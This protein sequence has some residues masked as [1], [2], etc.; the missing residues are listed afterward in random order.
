LF[1]FLPFGGGAFGTSKDQSISVDGSNVQTL[2]LGMAGHQAGVPSTWLDSST[3]AV[4]KTQVLLACTQSIGTAATMAG[5]GFYLARAGLLT[6]QTA[7]GLAKISM[8]LT[9]PCLLFSTIVDCQ[10]RIYH[11]SPFL[12]SFLSPDFSQALPG[13]QLEVR[14]HSPLFRSLYV[15]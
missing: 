4:S 7:K 11:L 3:G 9:I 10:V 15:L 14:R 5:S 6:P 13:N 12:N 2:Y 1:D 8:N